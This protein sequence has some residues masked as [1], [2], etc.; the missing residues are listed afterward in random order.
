M[1]RTLNLAAC[2]LERGRNLQRVGRGVEAERALNRLAGFRELPPEVA[3]ETQARL[4]ELALARRRYRRARRHLTAALAHGATTARY[5][6]LMARCLAAADRRGD[7]QRAADHYRRALRLE[8]KNAAAWAEFGP[9]ALRLG[10]TDEG[11]ASLRRAAELE[12]DDPSIVSALVDGLCEADQDD[13]ARSH[14]RAALFR[15][16]RDGR[17]RRLWEQFQLR[18][19]RRQQVER[20]AGIQEGGART[21]M[22]L[23]FLRVADTPAASAR[24]DIMAAD[25]CSLLPAAGRPRPRFLPARRRAQ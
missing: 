16:G 10:Q 9:L 20:R 11:L 2:L 15:N 6:L 25:E 24:A 5:H 21:P 14:L 22:V 19:T 7:A 12:P 23:P 13:E 1:S 8:P 17:F 18:Q 3:E 4:A